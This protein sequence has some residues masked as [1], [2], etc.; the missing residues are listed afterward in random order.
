MSKHFSNVIEGSGKERDGNENHLPASFVKRF[1]L[2]NVLIQKGYANGS[3]PILLYHAG[4][5]PQGE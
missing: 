2:L 3:N 1:P 5:G 4:V